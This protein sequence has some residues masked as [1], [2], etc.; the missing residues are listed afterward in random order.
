MDIAVFC[1]LVVSALGVW[2]H[3]YSLARRTDALARRTEVTEHDVR[4]KIDDTIGFMRRNVEEIQ[5]LRAEVVAVREANIAIHLELE[6]VRGEMRK[7]LP[8]DHPLLVERSADEI[9]MAVRDSW[10]DERPVTTPMFDYRQPIAPKPPKP[11]PRKRRAGGT[12]GFGPG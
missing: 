4:E 6:R 12:N 1:T 7:I 10:G 2:W 3:F 11:K 5:R 9:M 8:P